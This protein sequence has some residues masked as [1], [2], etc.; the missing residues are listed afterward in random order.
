MILVPTFLLLFLLVRGLPVFL[1]R[2]DL[3]PGGRRCPCVL[4]SA[5]ASLSI[6]VVI[7]EIG[8]HTERDER[9]RRRRA[10]GRGAAVRHALSHDCRRPAVGTAGS[11]PVHRGASHKACR[12]GRP[13][14]MPVDGRRHGAVRAVCRSCCVRRVPRQRGRARGAARITTSRCRPP[15][16][17]RCSAISP[18]RSL[19]TPARRR[20]S[21]AATAS[22]SSTPTARTASSPTTR[23]STRSASVRCSS[24]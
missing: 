7:T 24:I 14:G 20:P 12:G 11:L 22:S 4:A 1:Y 8:V 13:R 10:C 21:R 9:R 3:A 2:K 23:S 15:T 6:V 18:T 5:V 17:N 19:P 16:R